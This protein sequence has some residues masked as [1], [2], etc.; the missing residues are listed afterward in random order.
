MMYQA[1]LRPVKAGETIYHM[2]HGAYGVKYTSAEAALADWNKGT[3]FEIYGGPYCSKR[4]DIHAFIRLVD[5]TLV[6]AHGTPKEAP[7]EVPVLH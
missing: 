2:V 7:R 3:D 1:C 5:G 6:L 4:D